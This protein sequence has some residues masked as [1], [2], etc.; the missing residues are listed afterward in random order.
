MQ[1][2]PNFRNLG[3]GRIRRT[4]LADRVGPLVHVVEVIAHERDGDGDGRYLR[5]CGLWYALVN[6]AEAHTMEK[7]AEFT[8]IGIWTSLLPSKSMQEID[9]NAWWCGLEMAESS[10][11]MHNFT[12]LVYFGKWQKVIAPTLSSVSPKHS[13]FSAKSMAISEGLKTTW[14]IGWCDFEKAKR[15]VFTQCKKVVVTCRWW[16]CGW[17]CSWCRR[18]NSA[19]SWPACGPRRRTASPEEIGLW[20]FIL[21]SVQ[22]S[23]SNLLE[24]W[25]SQQQ[26][27][28]R[29]IRMSQSP[30]IIFGYVSRMAYPSTWPL[31]K[32]VF[33]QTSSKIFFKIW[34]F[35]TATSSSSIYWRQIQI[36][37]IPTFHGWTTTETG[38]L[39]P[40]SSLRW[41][42]WSG[43]TRPVSAI[44]TTYNFIDLSIFSIRFRHSSRFL[45]ISGYVSITQYLAKG[46][47]AEI[48]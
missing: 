31:E 39:R 4:H 28:K 17:Q 37:I 44:F 9:W 16:S 46:Q 27:V 12:I 18:S 48:L 38:S 25:P 34:N 1:N 33:L 6:V 42:S 35:S 41:T 15:K 43:C 24:G 23:N 10:H 40:A 13:R 5:W 22:K 47:V 30:R 36:W 26:L 19:W 11:A 8:S 45:A 20:S 14:C 2:C 7:H 21:I 3:K 32:I 29:E